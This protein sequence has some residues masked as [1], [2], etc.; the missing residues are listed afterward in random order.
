MDGVGD[1]VADADVDVGEDD[2]ALAGGGAEELQRPSV[3]IAVS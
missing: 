1:A 3:S 2:V